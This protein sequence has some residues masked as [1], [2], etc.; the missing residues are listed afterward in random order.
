MNLPQTIPPEWLQTMDGIFTK[1]QAKLKTEYSGIGTSRQIEKAFGARNAHTY[2]YDKENIKRKFIV[3]KDLENLKAVKNEE[4]SNGILGG[5]PVLVK[6]TSRTYKN[7]ITKQTSFS[8]KEFIDG[9]NNETYQMKVELIVHGKDVLGN[10]KKLTEM[11]NKK[12]IISFTYNKFEQVYSPL[13]LTNLSYSE[14]YKVQNAYIVNVDL[15]EVRL[16]NK[17]NKGVKVTNGTFKRTNKVKTVGNSLPKVNNSKE[18]RT[19]DYNEYK[20]LKEKYKND[21]NT[22]IVME[23][24]KKPKKIKDKFIYTR[25]YGEYRILKEK[26]RGYPEYHIYMRNNGGGINFTP[27]A[28]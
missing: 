6:S 17:K 8:K 13:V 5:I 26:Y 16:L 20:F 21:T 12:E 19:Q 18:I 1:I 22:H 23:V 28:N 15:E 10:L 11:F 24:R 9:M 3:R 14:D 4:R 2:S 7:S 25:D 27:R